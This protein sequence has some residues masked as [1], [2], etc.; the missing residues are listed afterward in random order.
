MSAK[1][2]INA[3]MLLCVDHSRQ[4]SHRGAEKETLET[5]ISDRNPVA[6]R[7]DVEKNLQN[8]LM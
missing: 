6:G 2:D 3:A 8:V 1:M 4:D 5:N 7:A